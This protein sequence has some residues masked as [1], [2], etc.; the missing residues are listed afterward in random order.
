[1]S[2][3]NNFRN[4][5]HTNCICSQCLIGTNLCRCFISRTSY[6]DIDTFIKLDT[7]F[8][9]HFMGSSTVFWCVGF[10]HI[11]ETWA[12]VIQVFTDQWVL[13]SHINMVSNSHQS[14]RTEA[15]TTSSISYNNT[16]TT[17][18]FHNTYRESYHF[19][20]ISFIKMETS[21]KSQYLTSRQSTIYKFTCMTDYC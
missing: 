5:G 16:F 2:C 20:R 11:R 3:H 6:T 8:L 9:S 15:N 1:M 12:E 7:K 18:S 17:K 13:T 19:K 10:R 14:T 4:S 21:L